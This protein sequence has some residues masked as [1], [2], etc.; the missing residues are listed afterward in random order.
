MKTKRSTDFHRF[1][2]WVACCSNPRLKVLGYRSVT[3]V[4]WS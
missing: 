1:R 4:V 3:V 2:S